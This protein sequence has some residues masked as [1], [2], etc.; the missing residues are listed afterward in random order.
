[1]AQQ[2]PWE[3][4]PPLEIIQISAIGFEDYRNEHRLYR[5]WS[6]GTIEYNTKGCYPWRPSG[7]CGWVVVPEVP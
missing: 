2:P 4:E 3:G 7:W 1:M 6:D 5:L